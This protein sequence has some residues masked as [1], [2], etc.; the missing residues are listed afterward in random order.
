MAIDSAKLN[1]LRLIKKPFIAEILAVYW[2]DSVTKYY[3]VDKY[4]EIVPHR[5]CP[6]KPIEA[7]LLG[8]TFH[9]FELNGD[10]R[11]ETINFTFD[12]IDG[13]IG[14]LFTTHDEGVRCELFYYFADADLLVSLWWGQ[15]NQPENADYKTLPV[16]ASNGFISG[17]SNLPNRIRPSSCVFTF[18][19]EISSV[20]ELETNG[21]KYDR[22]LGGSNGLLDGDDQPFRRCPKMTEA[23]CVNRF[24]HARYYGG[25]ARWDI[26]AVL[27][28]G[29]SGY[30]ATAK[31]SQG[32]LT[33][34]IRVIAGA[35][36]VSKMPV[37]W[38]RLAKVRLNK[39][40]IF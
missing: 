39:F 30:R 2:S 32:L 12:N 10:L 13:E 28:D 25:V 15:L 3:A 36:Y 40:L 24:G 1:A 7:R 5:T 26:Q 18:G 31:G 20:E 17:E 23:D 19:G 35:K 38:S 33:T 9:N 22:H 8:K 34:P 29:N 37:P 14:N 6:L 21:C 27:T 16:S 11:T 4:D